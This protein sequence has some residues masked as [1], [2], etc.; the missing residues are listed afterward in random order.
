ME[1]VGY[2]PHMNITTPHAVRQQ[3]AAAADEA[4]VRSVAITAIEEWDDC[5]V[6]VQRLTTQIAGLAQ[7]PLEAERARINAE[8]Q[9]L[10]KAMEAATNGMKNALDGA[11]RT[12]FLT[13]QQ[14]IAVELGRWEEAER[15]L[16]PAVPATRERI[17]QLQEQ[18][19]QAETRWQHEATQREVLRVQL[20]VATQ[21][22][23]AA[24]AAAAAQ[25]TG[26]F[27]RGAGGAVTVHLPFTPGRQDSAADRIKAV[28]QAGAVLKEFNQAGYT[29]IEVVRRL[30]LLVQTMELTPNTLLGA[31]QQ[32]SAEGRANVGLTTFADYES[33]E[34]LQQALARRLPKVTKRTFYKEE[35]HGD[36]PLE[37]HIKELEPVVSMLVAL[38]A[39]TEATLVHEILWDGIPAEGAYA[40]D[41]KWLL[42]LVRAANPT[43][44]TAAIN[45]VSGALRA[46]GA[47]QERL[48]AT[49]APGMAGFPPSKTLGT[50]GTPGGYVPPHAALIRTSQQ[51]ATPEQVEKWREVVCHGC[52]HKDMCGHT[53]GRYRTRSAWQRSTREPARAAKAQARGATTMERQPQQCPQAARRKAHRAQQQ[54]LLQQCQQR[55]HRTTQAVHRRHQ[56]GP[57]QDSGSLCQH[58]EL[59]YPQATHTTGE[60]LQS[61][62]MCTRSKGTGPTAST[63]YIWTQDASTAV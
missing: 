11:Q 63:R 7:D 42:D 18:V 4:A 59:R 53:V 54:H 10:W 30:A 37:Q 55:Q 52:N 38:G 58:E 51:D 2:L 22:L 48:S 17:S 23:A 28:Q 20:E 33:V 61:S 47:L 49:A 39:E 1:V 13:E 19:A 29:P 15:Q 50:S 36:R 26:V 62:Q 56:M 60:V 34:S 44:C 16:G 40:R 21:Q 3:L 14:Q 31:I 57:P 45:T 46:A 25:P 5:L 24:Y 41:N 35:Y 32:M 27:R 6:E 9:T 12:H 43:T 8:K